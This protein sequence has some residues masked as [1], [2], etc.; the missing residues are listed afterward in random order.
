MT[1]SEAIRRG[2]VLAQLQ[3]EGQDRHGIVGE[4]DATFTRHLFDDQQL[5]FDNP[6]L[7]VVLPRLPAPAYV[8]VEEDYTRWSKYK[9]LRTQ[10]VGVEVDEELDAKLTHHQVKTY[11][12]GE[13]EH[14]AFFLRLLILRERA[15]FEGHPGFGQITWRDGQEYVPTLHDL[16]L[17]DQFTRYQKAWEALQLLGRITVAP[18]HAGG[19]PRGSKDKNPDPTFPKRYAETY[20]QLFGV[21]QREPTQIE[22]AD[23]MGIS[24][25]TVT[26]RR[27]AYGVPLVPPRPPD[28]EIQSTE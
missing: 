27:D 9:D 22:I 8:V 19:R 23:D 28:S 3:L 10:R 18:R 2:T 24:T 4:F 15:R 21:N 6:I 20:W 13:N 26:R 1:G 7:Q 12:W 16:N 14:G 11:G 17:D 25:D 5:L